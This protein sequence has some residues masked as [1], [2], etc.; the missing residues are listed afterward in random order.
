M[1][2]EGRTAGRAPVTESAADDER[3]RQDTVTLA[4]TLAAALVERGR[5]EYPRS[6]NPAAP[7]APGP[8]SRAAPPSRR[9]SGVPDGGAA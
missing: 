7:G 3:L 4:V 6:R 9:R 8:D 5:P 1:P 2:T